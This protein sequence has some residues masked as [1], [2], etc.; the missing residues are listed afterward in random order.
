MITRTL[1]KKLH[2]LAGYYP[3]VVVTGPRQS[4]KTT[5]CKMAYPEKQY[6]SLETLD[7]RDFAG[8]DPRGFLARYSEGAILDEIQHVPELL[9][10]LQS[11]V[12]A[13]PD[14]GRFILRSG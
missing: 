10:Y 7:T 3:A 9:S 8:S 14:P 12:D 6:V 11:N 2:E 1:G 4:G 5:L 13:R